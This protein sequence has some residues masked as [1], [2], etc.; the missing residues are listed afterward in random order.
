MADKKTA[1]QT[2]AILIGPARFS[3]L[4]ALTPNSINGSKPKYSVSLLI[5]KSDK[6]QVSKINA[7]IKA[8]IIAKWGNKVPK[9]LDLPLRDGD[10]KDDENYAGH[11][12]INAKSDNKPGFVNKNRE[13]II[14]PSEIYSGMYGRAAV[15]FYGFDMTANKGVACGL[16]NLQKLKDG[17]AFSSRKKAEDDFDDEFVFTDDSDLE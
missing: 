17:P 1:E 12:Y 3:Y 4:Y 15:N 16:N 6:E 14:D 10:D 8:A 5:P 9:G 7:A 13:E 2:T 11:W